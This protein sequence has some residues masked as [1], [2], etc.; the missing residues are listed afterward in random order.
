MNSALERL[1]NVALF[2]ALLCV[3]LATI[4]CGGDESDANGMMENAGE[5][6][7][8]AMENAGGMMENAANGV[9]GMMDNAA[10]DV[11]DTMN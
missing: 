1:L 10:Q 2:V 11:G 9:G 4:G 3:P 6:M 8:N 7:E 5:H